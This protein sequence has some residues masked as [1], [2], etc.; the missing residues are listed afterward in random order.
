MCFFFNWVKVCVSVFKCFHPK[1]NIV[2]IYSAFLSFQACMTFKMILD[3]QTRLGQSAVIVRTSHIQSSGFSLPFA[4]TLTH[5]YPI[6]SA[7]CWLH[8]RS[9]SQ[10]HL[11]KLKIWHLIS[12]PL[13]KGDP[14]FTRCNMS[15]VSPECVC[16]VLA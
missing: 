14:F 12:Q 7:H 11:L 6:K 3:A 9:A 2:I 15:Q 13:F 16:E 10:K 1:I 5:F 4:N 8:D